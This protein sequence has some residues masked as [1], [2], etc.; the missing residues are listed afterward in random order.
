[1]YLKT[2]KINYLVFCGNTIDCCVHSTLRSAN[3]LGYKCLLLQDCCG[4]VNDNLFKWSIE[5][6]VIENGVFGAVTD[7]TSFIKGIKVIRDT[8]E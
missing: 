7:S 5:S 1:M 8:W 3:D 6:V 2:Q 4:A